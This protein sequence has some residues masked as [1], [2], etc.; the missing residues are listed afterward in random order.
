[1]A[2]KKETALRIFENRNSLAELIIIGPLW[3]QADEIDC[4]NVRACLR[5]QAEEI[6]AL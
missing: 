1:M 4:Y 5:T 3:H 2:T 6:N